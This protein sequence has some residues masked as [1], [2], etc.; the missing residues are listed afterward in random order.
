MITIRTLVRVV[1]AATLLA[2]SAAGV[3]LKAQPLRAPVAHMDLEIN[4]GR[5]ISL[6]HPAASVFVADPDIADVQIKSSKLIYVFARKPGETTLYTVD[7]SDRIVEGWRVTVAHNLTRLREALQQYVPGSRIEVSSVGDAVVLQGVVR[8][9]EAAEDARVLA[10]RLAGKDNVINRLTVN[11]PNQVNLRVRIAEVRRS[12]IKQLGINWDAVVAPGS[13]LFGLGTGNPAAV[14]VKDAIST[15]SPG[16]VLNGQEVLTRNVDAFGQ[17]STNSVFGTGRFGRFNITS[18]IDAL[19]NE[20]LVTVLAEPNL[21]AVSGETASFLAGG[22][23]PIPVPQGNNAVTIDFKKFGVGLAFTP[24]LLSGGQISLK[25]RPEVSQLTNTGAVR[26]NGFSI[27]AITT[28]RAETTVELGS[29]QSFA[30]AGLMQNDVNR[31]VKKLPGLGD[32]P[33]L[34]ALFR[35]DAFQRDESELVILVT[36]Y[37][38]RPTSD[39]MASP[40]DGLQMPSDTD[41]LKT[42]PLYVQKPMEQTPVPQGPEGRRLVGSAGFNLEQ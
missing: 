8:S 19:E 22:E 23:F 41:R 20:G 34:G 16:W 37:I 2:A 29:G 12:V 4:K 6:D 13:F 27:P 18:V 26:V 28:R 15:T 40:T 14:A 9:P 24:T 7:A 42:A 36:P 11:G 32:L 10:V 25:V 1:F 35:S 5:L 30:I 3:E 31:A 33:V 21:T 17:G 38:V 39:Q